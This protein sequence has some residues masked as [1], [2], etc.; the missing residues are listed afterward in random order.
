MMNMAMTNRQVAT[1][2]LLAAATGWAQSSLRAVVFDC[3]GEAWLRSGSYLCGLSVGQQTASGVLASGQYRAVLGFWHKPYAPPVGVRE[4]V[5]QQAVPL[6]FTMAQNSPNP[7]SRNTAI[8][9]SLPREAS[10]ALRVFNSAGRVV[11]TLVQGRQKPGR[12]TVSWDVGRVPASKLPCGT[13][14]CRLEAGDFT[15]TRKMVKTD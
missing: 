12:Y 3:G 14:F 11:T 6:T 13:Y 9:Y 2:L 1:V 4:E 15:A 10:V 5:G 7:F 8:R